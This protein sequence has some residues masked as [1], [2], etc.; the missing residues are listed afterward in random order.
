MNV[1][2]AIGVFEGKV[3]ARWLEATR[4]IMFDPANAYKVGLALSHAAIEAHEG[5]RQQKDIEFIGEEL[6]QIKIVVTDA[7][8]D[9]LVATVATILATLIEKKMTPGY[10][11]MHCVD[12]VLRETAR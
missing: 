9:M 11:A 8:R 4:E 3:I 1:D 7:Q 6:A 12:A 10:I 5:T 2:I